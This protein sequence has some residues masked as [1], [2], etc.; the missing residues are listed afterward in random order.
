MNVKK[1]F[2]RVLLWTDSD[3][4]AGTERHCLDLAGGLQRLGVD[5]V[6]GC[7]PE[8]PLAVKAAAAGIRSVALDTRWGGMQAVFRLSRML[9]NG[10]ADLVHVHNGK[11]A[12]LARCAVAR[13][14][15]GTLVASQHFISPAR[16][17]RR[18][19]WAKV[20][21]Q[22]HCWVDRGT[23]RW[24]S[25]SAAVGDG[26]LRRGDT[27]ARKIRLVLNGVTGGSP[28]E[29]DRGEARAVLG[30]PCD[31][32]IILC[33]A[34]L[35]PEKG[36]EVL[37]HALKMLSWEKLDFLALL[38][39]EGSLEAAITERI[40][41]LGISGRVRF[42]GQQ[43]DVSVWLR[44]ADV[45]VLPS[46]AEP[47]GLVLLEA[48]CREIPV[49]AAAAGG[50]LEI[51]ENGSGLL[52]APHDPRDLALKLFQLLRQPGLRESLAKAGYFRWAE[53]FSV[54]RMARETH[55]LYEEA[56]CM[57]TGKVAKQE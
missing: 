19:L 56:L 38:V 35:E 18:G 34:R 14:G 26:I 13:A 53:K 40:H 45:L 39:G 17:R 43:P 2:F 44:A 49:L 52:F 5:V 8:T 4:F 12:L 25:I 36:H 11:C 22:A 57:G 42:V 9:E 46:A 41:A 6:L 51:L 1:G 50:P 16:T 55:D 10:S 27:S 21:R 20:A 23:S 31:I 33:I 15:R 30:L 7:R 54:H 24:V 3:R 37:L 48:M 28:Q 47:F 32:P 29:L